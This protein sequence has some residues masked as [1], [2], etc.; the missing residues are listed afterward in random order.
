VWI[1]SV[2]AEL[3][4]IDIIGIDNVPNWARRDKDSYYFNLSPETVDEMKLFIKDL[5]EKKKT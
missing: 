4:A 2:V 1:Y 3:V 5:P